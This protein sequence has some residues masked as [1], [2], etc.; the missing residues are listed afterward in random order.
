MEGGHV[1]DFMDAF[2]YQSV[3][4]IF[5]GE[6]YFSDGITTMPDGR[7]SFFVIKIDENGEFLED[8]YEFTGNTIA[9]CVNAFESAPIWAGK[10]FYEIE[11][12]T[13]WVDW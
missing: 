3:A 2:T 7:H 8:V 1:N 4:L 12:E 13:E 9:D 6:K 10:T 5:R 11:R